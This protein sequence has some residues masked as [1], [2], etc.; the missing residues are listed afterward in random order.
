MALSVVNN[1]SS[2]TAQLALSN[3]TTA[4]NSSLEKLSTGLRINSGADDPSGLVVSNEQKAQIAGLNQ[5]ITNTSN[6][7]N[8]VQTGE[9]AS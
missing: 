2:L 1:I 9:G 7:V 4:L 3:T 8:L 6:A 5:A